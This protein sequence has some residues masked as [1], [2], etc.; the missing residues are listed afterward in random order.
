MD[1]IWIDFDGD[2]DLDLFFIGIWML[3]VLLV[4]EDG[5]WVCSEEEILFVQIE[6]WWYSIEVVD[7]D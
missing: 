5:K 6:G 1:V 7:L 3:F 2:K 4:N